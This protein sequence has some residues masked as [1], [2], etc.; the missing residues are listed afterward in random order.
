M[1]PFASHIGIGVPDKKA[2]WYNYAVSSRQ[3]DDW[4]DVG[5]RE[6]RLVIILSNCTRIVVQRKGMNTLPLTHSLQQNLI[7]KSCLSCSIN[8]QQAAG[9]L[10]RSPRHPDKYQRIVDT[11]H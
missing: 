11:V 7:N 8:D 6:P 5:G 9:T 1:L 10:A 2:L 3:G 4:E